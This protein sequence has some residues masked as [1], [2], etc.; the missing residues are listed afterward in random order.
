[1]PTARAINAAGMPIGYDPR[2]G[3]VPNVPT[4]STLSSN[5]RSILNQAI[6]GFTPLTKSASSIIGSALSG[7][8]PQDVQDQIQNSAAEQ[9]VAGG[10]PGSSRISG[11]LYGNRTLRDVGLTSLNQQQTG[12]KDLLSLLQGY[13][14]TA[15]PTFGQSQE[16][17]N[18]RAQYAAAPIPSEANAEQQRIFS[19]YSRNPGQPWWASPSNPFIPTTTRTLAGVM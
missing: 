16:Q 1:M 11:S 6:P 15:A 13:S 18:A 10:M 14:G 3:G 19:K 12:I 8:I 17:E 2:F 7:E 4:T 5:M 9:A